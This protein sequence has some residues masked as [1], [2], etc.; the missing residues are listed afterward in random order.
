MMMKMMML[1]PI[2]TSI[3]QE[4]LVK[5]GFGAQGGLMN[6]AMQI[7]VNPSYVLCFVFHFLKS[8]FCS[9]QSYESQDEEIKVGVAQLMGMISGNV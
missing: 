6:A 5:M 2:V 7:K 1:L 8:S 9:A 4:P 3:L